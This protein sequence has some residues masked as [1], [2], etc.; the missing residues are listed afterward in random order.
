MIRSIA[1]RKKYAI[2]KQSVRTL[3]EDVC[4]L[5]YTDKAMSY[6]SVEK[7]LTKESRKER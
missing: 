2:V 6:F 5:A 1:K 3:K 7:G 4:Q